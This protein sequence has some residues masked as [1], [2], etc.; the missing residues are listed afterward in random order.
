MLGIL[1]I[2]FTDHMKLKK[3]KEKNVHASVVFRKGN[4]IQKEMR[5]QSVEQRVKER[6]S[7]DCHT[8]GSIPHAV[9]KPSHY[10]GCQEMHADRSLI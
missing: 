10:W 8:W 5:S 7:R 9:I 3:K 6:P 2:K 4:K 1:K